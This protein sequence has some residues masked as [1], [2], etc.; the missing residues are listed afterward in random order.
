MLIPPGL[1]NQL[2]SIS[3]HMCETDTL[4]KEQDGKIK[5]KFHINELTNKKYLPT[6]STLSTQLLSSNFNPL[7]KLRL[8]ESDA[9][10]DDALWI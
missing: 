7:Q 10:N 5:L 8:C 6:C 2:Y 1:I 3:S 9:L 4:S